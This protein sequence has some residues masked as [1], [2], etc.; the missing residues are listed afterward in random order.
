MKEKEGGY[1]LGFK[2]RDQTNRSTPSAGCVSFFSIPFCP[3]AYPPFFSLS[4]RPPSLLLP[5]LT[6]SGRPYSPSFLLPAKSSQVSEARAIQKSRASTGPDSRPPRCYPKG[7]RK[8]G[9]RIGEWSNLANDSAR[10][11]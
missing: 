1:S 8:A 4:S 9:R 2:S 6:P 11:V 10:F 3:R 5:G 7:G